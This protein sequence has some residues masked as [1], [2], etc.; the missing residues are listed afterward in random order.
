MSIRHLLS[1]EHL[2]KGDRK[3]VEVRTKRR[4]K[5]RRSNTNH[6]IGERRAVFQQN[7]GPQAKVVLVLLFLLQA[8]LVENQLDVHVHRTC[9]RFQLRVVVVET[10]ESVFDLDR[11]IHRVQRG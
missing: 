3:E 8:L 4:S 6:M 2:V 10:V 5:R 11:L 9:V 1:F 7:A